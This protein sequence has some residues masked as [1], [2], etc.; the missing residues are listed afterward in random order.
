MTSAFQLVWCGYLFLFDLRIRGFDILPDVLGYL[1]ITLGLSRLSKIN[2]HF[3]R[4]ARVAPIAAL[5]SLTELYQPVA[6]GS[7]VLTLAGPSFKTPVGTVLTIAGI[8]LIGLNLLMTWHLIAGVIQLATREK[9]EVI[10]ERGANLWPEYRALH[11]MMMVVWP[12]S[13]LVPAMGWLAP[14]TKLS[15]G[16]AVYFNTMGFL[17]LARHAFRK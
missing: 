5:I 17:Q 11:I 16:I 13:A 2:D 4:A 14:L 3:A 10:T 7:G 8:L 9:E 6:S 1:L 12:L 15:V